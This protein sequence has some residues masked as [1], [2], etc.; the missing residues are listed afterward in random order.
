MECL[1]SC[2]DSVSNSIND[3]RIDKNI[4]NCRD[5]FCKQ[6]NIPKDSK[7]LLSVGRIC[8][9]KRQD[10]LIKSLSKILDENNIFLIFLGDIDPSEK[11]VELWIRIKEIENK[12]HIKS[13][14]RY[15]GY[16]KDV[17]DIMSFCDVL[18]HSSIT[19]AFGLVLVEAM[20]V[21]LPIVAINTEAMTEIV[22]Q[23][24][25]ILVDYNDSDAF[26]DAVIK[27]LNRTPKERKLVC[28][29][30]KSRGSS[31]K[32]NQQERTKIMTEYFQSLIT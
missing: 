26:R 19:E 31:S 13:N 23:P 32:Y 18:V 30:N 5:I 25:N 15:L 9:N 24:D 2:S 16:R 6:Q 29:R 10:F 27:I 11:G 3:S 8:Q 1:Y 22:D 21:G 12:F 14:I 7:L 4:V 20:F 28:S 17:M